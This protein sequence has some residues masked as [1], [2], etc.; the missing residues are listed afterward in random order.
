MSGVFDA[1]ERPNAIF[2]QR[3]FTFTMDTAK[4]NYIMS[5][6]QGRA[7]LWAQAYSSRVHLNM[8]EFPKFVKR[9]ELI[10]DQPDHRGRTPHSGGCGVERACIAKCISSGVNRVRERRAHWRSPPEG[11]R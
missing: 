3:P 10:F 8:L 11:P 6:L 9:F 4:I 2:S 7:L 1:I 5:L